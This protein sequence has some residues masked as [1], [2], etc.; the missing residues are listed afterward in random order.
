MFVVLS[1]EMRHGIKSNLGRA[2]RQGPLDA[3]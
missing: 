3:T 1:T 2:L